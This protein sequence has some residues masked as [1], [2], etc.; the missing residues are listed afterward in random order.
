[1]A[2]FWCSCQRSD[3][4]GKMTLDEFKEE[5]ILFMIKEIMNIDAMDVVKFTY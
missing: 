1:M 5:N 2:L 4:M 3:E